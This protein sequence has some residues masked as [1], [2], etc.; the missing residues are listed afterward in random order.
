MSDIKININTQGGAYITG[1]EFHDMEFV[2][3]KYVIIR[4]IQ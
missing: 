2:A 1:G 3:N 4:D